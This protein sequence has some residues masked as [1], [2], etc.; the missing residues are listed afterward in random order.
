VDGTIEEERVLHKT[1]QLV[2]ETV[3]EEKQVGVEPEETKEVK[4]GK[5]IELVYNLIWHGF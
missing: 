4:G 1:G 5:K 3:E 2:S